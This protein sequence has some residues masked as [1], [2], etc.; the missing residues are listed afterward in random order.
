MTTP[1]DGDG[2]DGAFIELFV[3]FGPVRDG[4]NYALKWLEPQ[5]L[6]RL[7]EDLFDADE[8]GDDIEPVLRAWTTAQALDDGGDDDGS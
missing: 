3:G 6:L 7:A 1:D 5:G 2:D 8:Q 4:R